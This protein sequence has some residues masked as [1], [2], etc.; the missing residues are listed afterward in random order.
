MI[1]GAGFASLL[2]SYKQYKAD[3]NK[4]MKQLNA[5][6]EDS[7]QSMPILDEERRGL[8]DSAV[9]IRKSFVH[10]IQTQFQHTIEDVGNGNNHII[11]QYAITGGVTGLGICLDL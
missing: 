3:G 7:T 1:L 9:C 10:Q 6:E 11:R 5:N 2:R 8:W 4:E